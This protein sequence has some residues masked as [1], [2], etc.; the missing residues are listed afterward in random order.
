[1]NIISGGQIELDRTNKER[2]KKTSDWWFWIIY[3][4]LCGFGL[5]L[6]AFIQ[7][8]LNNLR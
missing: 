2:K 8:L 1:M 7:G 4:L 5:I 6:G 3:F